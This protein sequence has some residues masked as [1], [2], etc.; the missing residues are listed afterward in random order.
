MFWLLFSLFAAFIG[1]YMNVWFLFLL[2]DNKPKILA[3]AKQHFFPKISIL[4][5]A[6]NEEKTIGR[7]LDSVLNL[8]YPASKLEAFVINNGSTDKTGR[9]VKKYE[10]K[11]NSIK[12][13]EIPEP[14]KSNALNE[15]LKIAKG[16]F[17]GFLDAD[18]FVTPDC[19]TKM[20]GHFKDPKVGAVTNFIKVNDPKGFLGSLQTVEYLFS[21]ISKKL[22]TFLNS[23]YITPGTLS[24]VRKEIANEIK[25]NSETITED[26]DFAITICKKGYKIV[27]T[28]DAV[29]YTTTPSTIKTLFK[30]RMRWYR[31]FIQNTVK[32]RDILF[33]KRFP[34]L[35]CFFIPSSF[36]GIFI[37]IALTYSLFSEALKEAA[38]NIRT[39]SY[40]PL[41]DQITLA[42]SSF[43]FDLKLLLL[44]PYMLILFACI[45][46]ST[47]FVIS[48]SLKTINQFNKKLA[49]LLPFY[50]LLYYTMIMIFWLFAFIL[51]LARCK[52]KW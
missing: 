43:G 27:N 50:M 18:T 46:A 34:D 20:L 13:I 37:G 8:K 15:G 29:T 33:N 1:I 23:L 32:H 10:R 7:T 28:M 35:G 47:I 12:L 5:P 48:V 17:I 26:M 11:Y 21:A 38:I 30:Q 6:N 9:I 31:G 42:V 39:S 52:K 14:S 4:I 16:K 44:S 45:F 51:E 36:I 25:F 24:L 41:T 2:F 3:E 22:L 40:L 49:V 19:L